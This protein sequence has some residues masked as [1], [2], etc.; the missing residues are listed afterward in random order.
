MFPQQHSL[1]TFPMHGQ[2]KL[3]TEGYRTRDGHLIEWFGRLLAP[4]SYVQ[5]VSRPM[6]FFLKK[7]YETS[8]VAKNTYPVDSYTVALPNPFNSKKWW[9]TSSERYPIGRLRDARAVISWSPF[10]FG[11]PGFRNFTEGL[12]VALDLLDDWSVHHAFRNISV[13]VE[14]AYRRAFARADIVFANSEGTKRLADR[15]GRDD[16]LLLP[17]G[18]DRESFSVTS[19]ASGP[20][21]IG[22]VGKIGKR[23]D[24]E[25]VLEIADAFPDWNFVFVG[26]FLD[27]GYKRPMRA[28]GNID[29]LGDVEYSY[30]PEVLK[31]FDLGW[32][33]HS[34]GQG[35]VG[36][37]AIK[38]YEYN[39]A[40]LPVLTTPII[41][42]GS[43]GL[44]D[45]H[46]L[47][48][49]QHKGFLRDL[50]A[51]KP[52]LARIEPSLAPDTSWQMKARV[53]LNELG[54]SESDIQ[55]SN[56]EMR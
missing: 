23:I 15:F 6:P 12:P 7:R 16:A 35:E 29:L 18:V 40:G 48:A 26:P 34:V 39:A 2:C 19:E 24:L 49:H 28:L 55:S 3:A 36:G 21:T 8:R 25:L 47:P 33:P 56:G 13:Q 11:A 46:V 45:V 22:Y 20:I 1:V 41:G 32:V 37:D 14:E 43:R 51:T 10:V 4:K 31:T 50:V 27:P 17:N 54:F 30:I 9:S 44:R 5:V 38:I 42:A 52:R 53:M